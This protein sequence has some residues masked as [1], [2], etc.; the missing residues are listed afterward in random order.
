MPPLEGLKVVDLTRVLAGPYCTMMLGDMG[1][2][3][4]KVEDPRGGDE[5]RGWLPFIG[6]ES[7]YYLG[8]NRNKRSVALDLKSPEGAAAL[9][10]LID[11][12]DIL[13]ENFRPGSLAALGFGYPE[14]SATHPHLIYCSI[15]GYGQTGPRAHEPGYDVVIQGESGFMDVTGEPDGEPMRA[16]VAVTDF[17]A[18]LY[19]VQGILLA[20][21]DRDRTGLGQHVDISLY[22][23]MLSILRLP[24]GVLLATGRTPV[25][26]GNDHPSIAPYETL[27][28]P[29][30]RVIVACGNRRLWERLCTAIERPDLPAD[31]RFATNAD[32]LANRAALKA[33][34]ETAFARYPLAELM[35][36]L[37]QHQVACGRVRSVADAV[38]DPQVRAR[39]M[40]VELVHPEQ[41]VVVNLG[42][43]VRLSRTPATMRLAPPM[44]GEHTREV[45]DGLARRRGP[46]PEP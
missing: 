4:V 31:P 43:P 10:G 44:L 28:A 40:W 46:A 38:A 34:L 36:R 30:G 42:S 8:V 35:R 1:A 27:H 3:V 13:V 17:L 29:E 11:G 32:R 33:E 15:S 14:L 26:V 25:R 20:L 37:Q 19:A 41:G 39:G 16:G 12:A 21:R 22:D 5:T 24:L 23:S 18:G 2:D 45:L 6:G 7:S 9:R